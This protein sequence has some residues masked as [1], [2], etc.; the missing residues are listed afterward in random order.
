MPLTFDLSLEELYSYKGRNP[1]PDDFEDFWSRSVSEL[2]SVHADPEII[3]AD[4][5]CS[6]ARC[7]HLYFNATDSA[8]I[9]AKLIRPKERASGAP[10]P[11]LLMF[12]GFTMD[13]GDW[14]GML[15]YAAA[16]FTVAAM[17]CRGQGGMTDDPGV[18]QGTSLHGHIIR[19]LE[20]ALQGEP[21][22]LL[23]RHMYLDTLQLSRL[24]KDLPEVDPQRIGV[25]GWSQGGGLTIA[26]AA[27]DPDIKRIAPVYPYLSD[28]QRV[29]E[30]D[31]AQHA[32]NGLREFFRHHDPMH[33]RE[34]EVFRNLGYI[35]I[36][37]LADRIRATTFMGIG[38]ADQICPPSTQFAA[39][40]RIPGEKKLAI[41]PDFGHEGLPRHNDSIFRFFMDL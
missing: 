29:W 41:Y 4:F 26:C 39:Y 16:G 27:L 20:S 28:Y 24:V 32:Y 25:T 36:Q 8:R 19:G 40:N 38:L 21:E 15:P 22:K 14:T 9:H 6:F 1:R 13:S 2:D 31:L 5:S 17:D 3:P 11:A 37:H 30:M 33:E 34:Q 10:G 23:Y 18:R 7:D 35:D 12:H